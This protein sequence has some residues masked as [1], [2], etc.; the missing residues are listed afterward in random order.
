MNP[1]L[2]MCSQIILLHRVL[3]GQSVSIQYSRSC[4]IPPG[5][6]EIKNKKY[7]TLCNNLKKKKTPK[8][9]SPGD[10]TM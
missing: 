7:G 10:A 5:K 8:P 6:F 9:I 1:Y 4:S 2:K 3:Q